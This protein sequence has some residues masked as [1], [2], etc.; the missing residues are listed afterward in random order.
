MK[1]LF[2]CLFL[3]AIPLFVMQSCVDKDY[4]WDELDTS[5]VI[6]IPPFFMGFDTIFIEGLPS[7]PEIPGGG[8]STPNIEVRTDT[9]HNIFGE[10]AVKNFFFE[11]AGDV[12]LEA[13][14]DFRLK[15]WNSSTSFDVDVYVTIINNDGNANSKV[16]IQPLNFS[17]GAKVGNEEVKT[18]PFVIKIESQYAQYMSEAEHMELTIVIKAT[19]IWFAN[20]DFIFIKDAV[21]KTGGYRYDEF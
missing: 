14:M 15:Y 5:G 1:R 13:N 16:K 4:D 18:E 17:I 6:N 11:G 8:I 7:L 21:F 12:A 19:S 10:D 20:D 9:I 2:K 3:I